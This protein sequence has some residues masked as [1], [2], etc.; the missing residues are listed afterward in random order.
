[1]PSSGMFSGTFSIFDSLYVRKGELYQ[2]NNIDLDKQ[3]LYLKEEFRSD[4]TYDDIIYNETIS[5]KIFEA[6]RYFSS[7]KKER[8]MKLKQ[9][10]SE[11][12]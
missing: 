9:I 3:L 4:S 2:I 12:I 11:N 6:D 10:M 8:R 5:I 7:I 1:M